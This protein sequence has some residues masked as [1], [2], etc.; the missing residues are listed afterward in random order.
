MF[1]P[2][3]FFLVYFASLIDI[4]DNIITYSLYIQ[5]YV[6]RTSTA[7]AEL[8]TGHVIP[9]ETRANG[10]ALTLGGSSSDVIRTI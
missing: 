10:T 8:Y 6:T 4:I 1:D 5:Y 2:I 7:M 9:K 3:L